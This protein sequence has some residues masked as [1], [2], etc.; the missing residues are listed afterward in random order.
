MTVIRSGRG[1]RGCSSSGSSL[2]VSSSSS[3]CST[4]P[5]SSMLLLLLLCLFIV[6]LGK[7]LIVFVGWLSKVSVL[8]LLLLLLILSSRSY[9]VEATCFSVGRRSVLLLFLITWLTSPSLLHL[10]PIVLSF[11][12]VVVEKNCCGVHMHE[13]CTRINVKNKPYECCS[14]FCTCENFTNFAKIT[15]LCTTQ[16]NQ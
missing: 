14:T 3:S 6:I 10:Y 12:V 5:T 2:P 15:Q 1:D 16:K 4:T 11:T 9:C 7:E 8:L 13:S